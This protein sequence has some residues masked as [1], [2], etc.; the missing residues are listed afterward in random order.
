MECVL[1]VDILDKIFFEYKIYSTYLTTYCI[2]VYTVFK[3]YMYFRLYT[4]ILLVNFRRRVDISSLC[5]AVCSYMF[6]FIQKEKLNVGLIEKLCQRFREAKYT[7][8]KFMHFSVLHMHF[9]SY[10]YP[11]F[12]GMPDS[13][14]ISLTAS[15]YS[16]IPMRRVFTN[17]SNATGF[18]PKRSLTTR[19]PNYSRAFL[20]KPAKTLPL[21]SNL[22]LLPLPVCFI[23]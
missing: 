19:S 8:S 20:K 11:L 13:R 9:R 7:K 3:L 21:L 10:F 2:V 6:Q 5:S 22:Q 16:V 1:C 14:A 4:W 12:V 17:W 15:H 18:M 23:S